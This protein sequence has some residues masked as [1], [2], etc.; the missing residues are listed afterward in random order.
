M[1]RIPVVIDVDMVTHFGDASTTWKQIIEGKSAI[2]KITQYD[3]EE[4]PEINSKV[5]GEVLNWEETLQS[6]VKEWDMAAN[7]KEF[8]K[9][10]KYA[11]RSTQFALVAAANI[12]KK[13]RRI[14]SIA[15]QK[16]GVIVGTGAAGHFLIDSKKEHMPEICKVYKLERNMSDRISSNQVLKDMISSATAATSKLLKLQG[17]PGTCSGACAS[18]NAS[19]IECCRRIILNEADVMLAIGSDACVTQYVMMGFNQMRALSSN[20]ISCPFSLNRDGFVMAE[21]AGAILVTSLD[22]AIKHSLPILALIAGYAE[23]S[24]ACNLALPGDQQHVCMEKAL[25]NAKILPHNINYINAHG[26]GTPEGDK[27]ETTEIKKVFGDYAYKIPVSS[28]KSMMG[29]GIGAAGIWESIFCILAINN[30]IIP[31]TINYNPDPE[32][33]LDYVPNTAR[34]AD[35][36]YAMNNSFGFGGHNGVI[37]FKKFSN[38]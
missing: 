25:T 24:D 9:I 26:T 17:P 16:S 22:F 34:E 1:N 29:H 7:N 19:I 35:V 4:F 10:I 37:I 8:F 15:P 14:F 27:H 20:G 5:A 11:N 28:T 33:D 21:G 30:S 12:A 36:K 18:G 13:Y 2:A 3:I 32:C 38:L 31:P 23:T 6:M